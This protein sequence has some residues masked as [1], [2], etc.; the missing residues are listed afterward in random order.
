MSDDVRN[1]IIVCVEGND[2]ITDYADYG[3]TFDS[4]DNEI[5]TRLSSA[6]TERFGVNINDDESGWLYKTRKALDSQNIYVIPN[7]T[8][9]LR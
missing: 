2:W 9:G 4:S 1:K 8:A 6:I 5:L 7:S 3:L